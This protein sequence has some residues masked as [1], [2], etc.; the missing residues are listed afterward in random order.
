MREIRGQHLGRHAQRRLDPAELVFEAAIF[1]REQV[2]LVVI[3]AGPVVVVGVGPKGGN[4]V[5]W[6]GHGTIPRR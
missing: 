6:A 4:V 1:F 5:R 3:V 2:I